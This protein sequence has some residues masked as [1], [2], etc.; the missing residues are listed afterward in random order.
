MSG[1]FSAATVEEGIQDDDISTVMNST[2]Y[3]LSHFTLLLE[4]QQ[5]Q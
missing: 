4:V 5:L 3:F 2:A 1:E